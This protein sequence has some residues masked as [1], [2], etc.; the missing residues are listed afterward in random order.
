MDQDMEVRIDRFFTDSR[1]TKCFATKC[2]FNSRMRCN[3]KEISLDH[4]ARCRWFEDR[5]AQP[6]EN[7]ET[8]EMERNR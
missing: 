5:S 6:E 3:L 8:L 1:M 4:E 2:R 7:G